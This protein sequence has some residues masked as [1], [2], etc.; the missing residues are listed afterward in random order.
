MSSEYS[1]KMARQQRL[2]ENAEAMLK[3][4]KDLI[5]PLNPT[6]DLRIKAVMIISQIEGELK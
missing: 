2:I 1:Q 5:D 3:V 6:L 4:L